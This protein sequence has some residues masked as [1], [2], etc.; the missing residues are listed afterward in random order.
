MARFLLSCH[1][2]AAL[3]PEGPTVNSQGRRPLDLESTTPLSNSEGVTE[4]RYAGRAPRGQWSFQDERHGPRRPRFLFCR[5]SGAFLLGGSPSRGSRPWLL[6]S[7]PPGLFD[8]AQRISLTSDR[9]PEPLYN[10]GHGH[11]FCGFLR[12]QRNRE[13]APTNHWVAP[14]YLSIFFNDTHSLGDR[15][16]RR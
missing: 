5:P 4:G 14:F 10:T 2:H 16:R 15:R 3:R 8:R 12:N 13:F 9:L 7:A 11:G 6:T 1:R